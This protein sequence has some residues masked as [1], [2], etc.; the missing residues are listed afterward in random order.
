MCV[1]KSEST[2]DFPVVNILPSSAGGVQVQALVG[3]LRSDMPC[4]QKTPKSI[5]IMS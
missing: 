2:G 4:G 1:L 5:E 3:E